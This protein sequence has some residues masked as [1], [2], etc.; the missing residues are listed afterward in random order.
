LPL[1][2]FAPGD[3]QSDKSESGDEQNFLG[4]NNY[5]I[6]VRG[7]CCAHE[8]GQRSQRVA[9]HDWASL[10][11]EGSQLVEARGQADAKQRQGRHHADEP[12]RPGE[13]EQD[14][15]NPRAEPGSH[16]GRRE[17]A[18]LAHRLFLSC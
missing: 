18:L 9:A 14:C 16:H 10:R 11:R 4:E 6:G 2:G 13:Q 15:S 7:E 8:G 1:P 5:W 17:C 3:Y 12:A